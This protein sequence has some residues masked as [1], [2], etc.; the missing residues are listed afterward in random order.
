MS[1]RISDAGGRRGAQTSRFPPDS[2]ALLVE[3]GRRLIGAPDLHSVLGRASAFLV[4]ALADWYLLAL[5]QADGHLRGVALEHRDE[6][7]R[8]V[9]ARLT[10]TSIFDCPSESAMA[11]AAQGTL[12][13]IPKIPADSG[14]PNGNVCGW[15]TADFAR[16]GTGSVVCAPLQQAGG[17]I[18]V[19]LLAREAPHGY[20][21]ATVEVA[22]EIAHRVAIQIANGSRFAALEER[23]QQMNDMVAI[24]AHELRTPTAAMRGFAQL[25]LRQIERGESMIAAEDVQFALARIDQQAVRLAG[26]VDR[27]M[28]A[29]RLDNGKLPLK[30][31]VIDLRQLV[32]DIVDL[33]RAWA[34]G[35]VITIEAPSPI[36]ADLDAQRIEQVLSNLIDNA[37]KFSP[38]DAPVE[39]TLRVRRPGTAVLSV[40]DHG[41]G[42]PAERRDRI[43]D[44]FVQAH[45]DRSPAGLGLGLYVS[46]HI[47]QQHG[48][49]LSADYPA[50]G[51]A[52]F[53]VELPVLEAAPTEHLTSLSEHGGRAHGN[54]R[55]QSDWSSRSFPR[56]R[57]SVFRAPRIDRTPGLSGSLA[58]NASA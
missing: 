38:S 41:V 50:D 15:S 17:T 55:A 3:S 26:L 21:R 56:W 35:R 4:P 36:R 42:I 40:R 24:A 31:E 6:R 51:G 43:F 58:A 13:W 30:R 46:Q 2:M 18:G 11:H 25:L 48:G 22:A 7:R 37:F 34:P 32:F 57:A 23:V 5:T 12:G 47:V 20:D 9:L 53:I 44:R 54:A 8:E 45:R 39:L 33:V 1:P 29:A 16:L 10:A 19:L 28:D 27:L 49:C 14:A 52:R